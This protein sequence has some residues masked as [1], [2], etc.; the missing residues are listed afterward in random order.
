MP[1]LLEYE[2]VGQD[3][4]PEEPLVGE[5]IHAIDQGDG[6]SLRAALA[7]LHPAE[8]ANLVESIPERDREDLWGFVPEEQAAEVMANL[9]D[10]AR[11]S[12]VEELAPEALT[13]CRGH[14]IGRPGRPG[15]E[16]ARR[17]WR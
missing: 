14:G 10:V 7:D 8:S 4:S 5:V 9:G 6:E 17:P 3:V 16:S 11:E 12:L 15:R 2:Y 13:S 1:L